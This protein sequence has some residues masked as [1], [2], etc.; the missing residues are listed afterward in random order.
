MSGANSPRKASG[1]RSSSSSR[2]R[3]LENEVQG[4][5]SIAPWYLPARMAFRNVQGATILYP[6]LFCTIWFLNWCRTSCRNVGY[7]RSGS[8]GAGVH[9]SMDLSIAV[10]YLSRVA[11][12]ARSSK[13]KDP[14]STRGPT[15]RYRN[16]SPLPGE[17]SH[18]FA[19]PVLVT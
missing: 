15:K 1:P 7:A 17:S 8:C 19:P 6:L 3:A 12:K 13:S 5:A 4:G 14:A 2:R 18:S 11:P 10:S 16:R 9:K